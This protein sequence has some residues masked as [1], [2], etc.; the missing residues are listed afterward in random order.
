[1][2]LKQV[3]FGSSEHWQAIQLRNEC[4]RKPIGFPFL[5]DF[6]EEESDWLHF[7]SLN[8][9]DKVLACVV[10]IHQGNRETRLRQMAVRHDVQRQGIGRELL[11]FAEKELG[12]AGIKKIIVHARANAAGFYSKCGY[13]KVGNEFIEVSIPHFKLNKIL[14]RGGSANETG[15]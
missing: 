14:T 5:T 10:A 8:Q 4:L 3:T 1:V 9:D 12:Q 11:F 7:V 2:K 6:P 15:E 13:Q